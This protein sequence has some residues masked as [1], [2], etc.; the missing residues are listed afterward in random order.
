M[1]SLQQTKPAQTVKGQGMTR[2]HLEK[3][4]KLGLA[5]SYFWTASVHG[6]LGR[7]V[8]RHFFTREAARYWAKCCGKKLAHLQKVEK[9]NFRLLVKP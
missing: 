9:E 5:R 1:S 4:L 6:N 8:T 3:R 2:T 7:I